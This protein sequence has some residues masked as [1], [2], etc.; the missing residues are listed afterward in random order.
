M[1]LSCS[2][3]INIPCICYGIKSLTVLIVHAGTVLRKHTCMQ[4]LALDHDTHADGALLMP[5]VMVQEVYSSLAMLL[6]FG[7]GETRPANSQLCR[8]LTFP[9]KLLT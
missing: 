9:H 8:E 1:A 3:C 7:S 4:G 2:N 6:A 5:C